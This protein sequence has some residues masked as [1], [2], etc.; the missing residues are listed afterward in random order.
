[1]RTIIISSCRNILLVSYNS[2]IVLIAK[3]KEINC[4]IIEDIKMCLNKKRT[5][6]HKLILLFKYN[7]YNNNNN[8]ECHHET[9]F[10]T[11]WVSVLESV[12]TE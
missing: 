12:T 6:T 7:K 5:V 2:T 4:F 3:K 11:S 1:M 10:L 9:L 8:N